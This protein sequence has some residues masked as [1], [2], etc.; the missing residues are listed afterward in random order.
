MVTA[1]SYAHRVFVDAGPILLIY[2]HW[3]FRLLHT[4]NNLKL[5]VTLYVFVYAPES[6]YI[7]H[8]ASWTLN[9][10]AEGL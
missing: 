6:G 9:S 4:R 7:Y 8:S 1:R 10:N 5:E 2:L 3:L